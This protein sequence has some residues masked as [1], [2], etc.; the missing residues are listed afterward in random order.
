MI[1][2]LEV[3]LTLFT[4][5]CK[6]SWPPRWERYSNNPNLNICRREWYVY[7]CVCVFG[8]VA[9]DDGVCLA[10]WLSNN[11]VKCP[12]MSILY[13]LDPRSCLSSHRHHYTAGQ[14]G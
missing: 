2:D 14:H 5:R 4:R 9:R 13:F 8:R 10:G 12:I 6:A 3:D 11:Q 1:D 7:T